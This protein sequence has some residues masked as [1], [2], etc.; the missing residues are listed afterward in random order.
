MMKGGRGMSS[1]VTSAF[2]VLPEHLGQLGPEQA[3][4]F[5]SEL[6]CAEAAADGLALTLI[7]VPSNIDA[8]DG[9]IDAD[10]EIPDS[11][12]GDLLA[13]RCKKYQVKAGS[14]AASSDT[15]VKDILFKPE[16][17]QLRDRV[18]SCLDAGE[19]LTVVLFGWDD[20]DRTE[21]Y[22]LGR[23][24]AFLA[25]EDQKYAKAEIRILRQNNLV[26]LF[27]KYPSIAL[28]LNGRDVSGLQS[29]DGWSRQATMGTSLHLGEKETKIVSAVQGLL[30]EGDVARH[31]HMFGEPGIGKTRLALEATRADDLRPLVLYTN[32]PKELM[33]S[34][35]LDALLLRDNR[36][37]AILVVDECDIEH[38]TT[39]W[40]QMSGLGPRISLLS[41]HN[42]EI[43]TTGNTDEVGLKP[44]D[45]EQ[46]KEILRDYGVHP[47]HQERW[48]ELCSG[49]PRVAH[50]VGT[51]LQKNPGDVLQSLDNV[52]IWG[53]YVAGD[54]SPD[55]AEVR[56]RRVVL[57]YLALFKRVGYGAAVQA[58]ARFIS[59]RIM[60]AD[61]N[62]TWIRFK[63]IVS[64][65]RD[66][67]I[68]QGEDTLYITPKALHIKLWRDWWHA[69]GEGFGVPDFLRNLPGKLQEWFVEMFRYAAMSGATGTLVQRLLG[70]GGP[71]EDLEFL[72]S[73]LGG[74]FFL[75]LTEASSGD[76]L[77]LLE[78]VVGN[79]SL[80]EVQQI[81]AG[82]RHMVRALECV[83]VWRENFTR[84]ARLLL[85]LAEAENEDWANNATGVFVGL[86]SPGPG[87]TAPTEAPPLERLPL[88]VEE[89]DTSTGKRRSI[90]LKA[91]DAALQTGQFFRVA[92][93]EYQGLHREPDL[94]M[95]KTYGEWH[96]GYRQAWRALRTYVEKQ[97]AEILVEAGQVLLT[98][99]RGVGR[100]KDF[101]DEVIETLRYLASADDR[102]RK[103][104]IKTALDVLH[105]EADKRDPELL[106]RWQKLHDDL[107]GVGFSAELRRYVGMNVFEDGYI[108]GGEKSDAKELRLGRLAKEAL[109]EVDQLVPELKWLVTESAENGYAFGRKLGEADA[110]TAMLESI[111]KAQR[112][113][114]ANGNPFFLA[115]YLAA[116]RERDVEQWEE[117][118]DGFT[119]DDD[120]RRFVAE[121]TWRGGLSD[122]SVGRVLNL[123]KNGAVD[124]VQLRYLT[125]G[126]AVRDLSEAA[127]QELVDYLLERRTPFCASMA[128]QVIDYY[129][130]KRGS[131]LPMPDELPLKVLLDPVV[132]RGVPGERRDHLDDY[133]WAA[134]ASRYLKRHPERGPEIGRALISEFE[135]DDSL[136]DFAHDHARGVLRDLI[137]RHPRE[138]WPTIRAN[139]GPPFD[140]GKYKFG[141]FL[142]GLD[143]FGD[144]GSEDDAISS[145]PLDELWKWIDE[146]VENRAWY[147]ATIV[148]KSLSGSDTRPSLTRELLIRYGHRDD[149]RRNLAANFSTEGW[150]GPATQHLAGK[151]EWL[152]QQRTNETERNVLRWIDEYI[153]SLEQEREMERVREEREF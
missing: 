71:C 57:Q 64:E 16:G 121:L 117:L 13:P 78:R 33:R 136:V 118:L 102:L 97:E 42:E 28:R 89:L 8:R 112:N 137:R 140:G 106:K 95:P 85:T 113:A 129:Y 82:R 84:A 39:I 47:E 104:V 81:D 29:W 127:I 146:D 37:H 35:L 14:F 88:L 52:D 9:G 107:S 87:R 31:V 68:L 151:I 15:G 58:E 46:V 134:V 77:A 40:N 86:F 98:N 126:G 100:I 153:T 123:A 80:D 21:D 67:H 41:I 65:L 34:R 141:M 6:L 148:P 12:K 92:G 99:A 48:A 70:P 144:V 108:P 94:W 132:V 73:S 105:Y 7:N 50:V 120:L 63:Q 22:L 79:L 114:G 133:H 131:G 2:S 20:P 59:D 74:R 49:S 124:D 125:F 54:D 24:R 26:H 32:Q 44:L 130:E 128:V 149:V 152:R 147:M 96:E 66:R 5:F 30:R 11:A 23:F 3:V 76:A 43:R 51:N 122:R 72:N 69:Y 75:A 45:E 53:R 19:V 27:E 60:E 1:G 143:F 61:P 139:L 4:R 142:R 93:A 138:L 116:V 25:K 83:A 17:K 38:R 119:H 18:K 109:A 150:S 62:I 36:F 10:V 145:L 115:G 56:Q 111:L 101:E 91:F 135:H 103:G 55:S 110:G 90:V